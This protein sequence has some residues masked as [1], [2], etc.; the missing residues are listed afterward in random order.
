MCPFSDWF[1]SDSS[2]SSQTCG[3]NAFHYNDVSWIDKKKKTEATQKASWIKR[4]QL[5]VQMVQESLQTC[6]KAK[7]RRVSGKSSGVQKGSVE[8]KS[9]GRITGKSPYNSFLL[10]LNTKH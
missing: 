1:Y 10:L 9:I 8:G 4:L 6:E 5:K 3:T 7:E 2:L